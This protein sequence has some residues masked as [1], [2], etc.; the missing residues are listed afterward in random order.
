MEDELRMKRIIIGL[1]ILTVLILSGCAEIKEI[2]G[3][4]DCE[5]TFYKGFGNNTISC[6][7]AQRHDC[8]VTL[9]NCD[10]EFQY[11]CVKDVKSRVKCT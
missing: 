6:E 9:W 10:D 3:I 11:E 1:L 4:K 5:T 2:Y 8:G 7:D